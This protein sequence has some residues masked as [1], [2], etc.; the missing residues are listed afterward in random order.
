MA[1]PPRRTGSRRAARTR[2]PTTC[3]RFPQRRRL[4][5]ARTRLAPG[6]G[7]RARACKTAAAPRQWSRRPCSTSR[8]T[9]SAS[10]ARRTCMG[11]AKRAIVSSS[12]QSS[13]LAPARVSSAPASSATPT[14]RSQTAL[15]PAPLHT[16]I[17]IMRRTSPVL[18]ALTRI[19]AAC[20]T[21]LTLSR[22]ARRGAPL[23][24]PMLTAPTITAR[25]ARRISL[26][27]TWHWS[28]LQPQQKCAPTTRISAAS[29]F[30][31]TTSST[32]FSPRITTSRSMTWTWFG[33][34][35]P[36]SPI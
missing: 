15:P 5:P 16:P 33:T 10:T 36:T 14:Q 25:C 30:S 23:S 28:C 12:S 35:K 21:V 9:S 1:C 3:R 8:F 27:T 6:D 13:R 22:C 2:W 24:A 17:A 18:P 11:C 34:L 20:F 29:T 32:R 7:T 19:T 31:R 26:S 4:G